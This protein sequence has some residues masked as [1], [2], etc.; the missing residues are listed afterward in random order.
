LPGASDSAASA[1][2]APA[3]NMKMLFLCLLMISI[4]MAS[5]FGQP[6]PAAKRRTT[7]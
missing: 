7:D 4:M 2:P 5:H 6:I 3:T 1:Q